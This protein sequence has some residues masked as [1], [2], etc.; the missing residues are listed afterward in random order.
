M[1]YKRLEMN[2]NRKKEIDQTL[3]LAGW[4]LISWTSIMSGLTIITTGTLDVCVIQQMSP[5]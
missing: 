4:T 5:G 2:T 3:A 1:Y